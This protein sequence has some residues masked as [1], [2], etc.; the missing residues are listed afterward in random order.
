[1]MMVK[2]LLASLLY[3]AT[4]RLRPYE[5]QC[6]EQF[7]EKLGPDASSL[8]RRQL[9]A[10]PL[11]RR[12]AQG[13]MVLFHFPEGTQSHLP[14]FSNRAPE[15]RVAR[16]VLKAESGEQLRSDIV[17]HEGRISSLEFSKPPKTILSAGEFQL[18]KVDIYQDLMTRNSCAPSGSADDSTGLLNELCQRFDLKDL[19]APVSE[20]DLSRY[21][22]QTPTVFPDDLVALLRETNGF[23]VRGWTFYG[24]NPRRL[25]I[26][27]ENLQITAEDAEGNAL[28]FRE[29]ETTPAVLL[30]DQ[31]D[32]ET[33]KIWSSFLDALTEVLRRSRARNHRRDSTTLSNQTGH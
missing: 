21:L 18:Q 6:L 22:A 3:G 1:M 14:R 17:F 10:R 31:I 16:M 24:T 7:R 12:H 9:D 4:P 33:K 2:K 20:R 15:L 26:P 19:V 29:D 30:Y 23:S 27:D 8:F 25:V 5:G 11:V 13:K 28:C 32:N